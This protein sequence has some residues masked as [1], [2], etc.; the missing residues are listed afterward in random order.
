[1]PRLRK[2]LIQA[3]EKEIDS[4]F[5]LA[6]TKFLGDGS[7][8]LRGMYE[9]A[10]REE[11]A[12]ID[13]S[14]LHGMAITAQ[15]FLDG[16]RSRAKGMTIQLVQSF[17]IKGIK[18][19]D[20][21]LYMR[22]LLDKIWSDISNNMR[23]ILECEI[24]RAKNMGLLQGI[25]KQNSYVGVDDPLIYFETAKDH[26]ICDECR[27][28]H[29]LSNGATPRVWKFSELSGGF[30]KKGQKTPKIQGLHP[31]CRCAL[32]TILPGYTFSKSGR[33]QWAGVLHNEWKKQRG[34]D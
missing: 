28:L 23:T 12:Q 14:A 2:V 10:A 15:H 22:P 25:I 6:Q 7:M 9:A 13:E 17:T 29:L 20:I 27:D 5:D 1:M 11:N 26:L 16:L 8:S 34:R 24:Q 21:D 31:S 32:R 18:K 3:I 30:H 4:L 33:I 19:E